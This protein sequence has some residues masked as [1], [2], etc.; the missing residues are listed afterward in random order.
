MKKSNLKS[1]VVQPSPVRGGG[2]Y[3]GRNFALSYNYWRSRGD[4]FT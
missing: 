4:Y 1:L 3:D 2:L